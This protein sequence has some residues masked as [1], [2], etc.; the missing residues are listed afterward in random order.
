[1]HITVAPC[2]NPCYPSDVFAASS[3]AICSAVKY[4]PMYNAVFITLTTLF[5]MIYYEEYTGLDTKSAIL[6]VIGVCTVVL[7]V[8]VLMLNPESKEQASSKIAPTSASDDDGV[9]AE[10]ERSS[11]ASGVK[12]DSASVQPAQAVPS[13]TQVPTTAETAQKSLTAP[14]SPAVTTEVHAA[15]PAPPARLPPLEISPTKAPAKLP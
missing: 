11:E 3:Q 15:S 10:L 8:L 12:S 7:G 6:F 5:G 4:F 9:F 14:P 13:P 2:M 1:M